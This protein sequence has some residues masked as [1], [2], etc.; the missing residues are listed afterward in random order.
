MTYQSPPE[1]PD[2]TGNRQYERK[3]TYTIVAA[4]VAMAILAVVFAWPRGNSVQQHTGVQEKPATSS[5]A[6]PP[7]K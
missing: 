5:P 4:G 3:V 2:E 1:R 7:A 6:A